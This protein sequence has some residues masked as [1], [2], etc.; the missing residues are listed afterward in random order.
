MVVVSLSRN[1]D[2]IFED[3]KSYLLRLAK[4]EKGGF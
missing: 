1:L 3:Q 2:G 4:Q